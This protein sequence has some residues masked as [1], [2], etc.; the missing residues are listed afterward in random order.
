[1]ND[2]STATN[3]TERK[4]HRAPSSTGW[5]LLLLAAQALASDSATRHDFDMLQANLRVRKDEFIPEKHRMEVA[6]AVSAAASHISVFYWPDEFSEFLDTQLGKESL[7]KLLVGSGFEIRECDCPV[8][9]GY[10][11]MKTDPDMQAVAEAILRN[12]PSLIL[13]ALLSSLM[14]K[15]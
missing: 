4:V 13:G 7:Q 5:E 9:I 15:D 1:M 6:L 2:E 14:G 12:N 8:G 3:T 11:V 10:Y